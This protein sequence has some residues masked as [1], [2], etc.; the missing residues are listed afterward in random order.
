M[1]KMTPTVISSLGL[2]TLFFFHGGVDALAAVFAWW[3]VPET[4]GKTLTELCSIYS[5]D[6]K[7]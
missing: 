1:V 5:Q 7:I 2:H 6:Q 3:A 4:K